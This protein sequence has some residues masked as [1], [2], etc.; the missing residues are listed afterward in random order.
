MDGDA[1]RAAQ[2]H[3]GDGG[4][5]GVAVHHLP[6]G[7]FHGDDVAVLE[8]HD[9][10][11]ALVL[12]CE[13]THGAE[14]AV[15]VLAIGVVAQG[16]DSR[17]FLEYQSLGGQHVLFESVDQVGRACCLGVELVR[18]KHDLVQAHVVEIVG[19]PVHREQVDGDLAGL[20]QFAQTSDEH[21]TVGLGHVA[22][23]NV[24]EHGQQF[25]GILTVLFGQIADHR[26]EFGPYQR[27]GDE[28]FGVQ[29]G[30]GIPFAT[31]D[32]FGR[33]GD[34]VAVAPGH[35]NR[36]Q[37]EEVA[38][39]HDLDASERAW[40]ATHFAADLV[41]HVEQPCVQHGNLVDDEDVRS[42]NL[43]FAPGFDEFEQ[44]R[45]QGGGHADATPRMDGLAVDMRGGDACGRGDCHAGAVGPSLADELVQD[46]GLTG[47]GRTGQEHVR[48]GVQNG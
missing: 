4:E 31:G 39:Q 42:L 34:E 5:H 13:A 37:L 23:A 47:T 18:L 24:G 20:G 17:A 44:T 43:A 11:A 15:D 36:R 29:A 2:R 1:P 35:R 32:E 40:V 16:H 7:L 45:A 12:L 3:L 22:F 6:C 26:V 30:T 46:I 28:A 38:G 21:V 14:R 48:A 41:D 33:G 19:L 8:F 25:A 27:F 9:R 10:P